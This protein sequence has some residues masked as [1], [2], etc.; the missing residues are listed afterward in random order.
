VAAVSAPTV[1]VT[2]CGAP[3]FAGTLWSLRENDDGR[4]L[5]VVGVDVRREQAGRLLADDF[6]RVP[7]ADD[8]R[9][10]D[11]LLAVCRSASV[12]VVL[13]Q[14][15]RELPVLA[16]HREEFAAAGTT[17]AVAGPE[18][19][20]RANDKYAL[21]EL[22]AD[23]GVPTPETTK[24]ATAGE[25]ED[26][27]DDLGYPDVPVVVKPPTSNGSRGMRVLDE[28]RDRKRAFYEEKPDG[29]H[30]TLA[31][32]QAILGESFPSLLVMEYLPGDEYTVDAFRTPEGATEARSVAIPRRR[33]EIRAGISFRATVERDDEIIAYTDRL[34][35]AL[36]CAYA[37][38]FQFKRDA[39]GRPKLLESNPRIQGTM[40][41]STLAG[42]NLVD[43][44]VRAALD[45]PVAPLDPDW[46]RAFY[47]Y[48][49]GVGTDGDDIVGNIG[50]RR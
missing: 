1:L 30:S 10:V 2:G 46:D 47:R 38:G 9:F 31:D 26:A 8:E 18:T 12:D 36:E 19:V 21:A 16:R 44:S 50:E 39:D 11:E 49:G 32:L 48:W 23:V 13:P 20:D 14:V 43:A 33:D 6:Y 25:L 42:A 35:D 22:A 4:D 7:P 37:F 15:T 17:V 27:C 41:T 34:A 24:V 40:V 29:T 45:E 5:A 28:R 3:G